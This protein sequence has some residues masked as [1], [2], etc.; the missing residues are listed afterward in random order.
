M[1]IALDN[2]SE[3]HNCKHIQRDAHHVANTRQHAAIDYTAFSHAHK[4]EV[5]PD[6]DLEDAEGLEDKGFGFWE[7]GEVR[8][9]T[10]GNDGECKHSTW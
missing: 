3:C 1:L 6:A 2:R 4:Q 8:G 5:D 9:G 7:H 10:G